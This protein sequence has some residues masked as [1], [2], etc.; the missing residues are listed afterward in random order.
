[1]LGLEARARDR[2]WRQQLAIKASNILSLGM[3]KST[4]TLTIIHLSKTFISY[5]QGPHFQ[6]KIN[7][8]EKILWLFQ[9]TNS[10]WI[11]PYIIY[12]SFIQWIYPLNN[13]IGEAGCY[14]MNIL[15]HSAQMR[16]LKKVWKTQ[17]GPSQGNRA[18]SRGPQ[19]TK[20]EI[21]LNR[22]HHH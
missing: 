12:F 5:K 4:S 19:S 8:S 11:G 20:F 9:V 18:W 22:D 21:L 6:T 13:L 10:I 1:M 16:N 15:R 17:T 3:V 2:G 14:L 7:K